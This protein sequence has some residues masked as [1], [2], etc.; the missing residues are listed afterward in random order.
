MIKL[1]LVVAIAVVWYAASHGRAQESE[2]ELTTI[3][4]EI[5]ERPVEVH[6][7]GFVAALLDV[8]SDSGTVSFKDGRPADDTKLKRKVCKALGRF[9][10]DV[11]TPRFA[12]VE[13]GSRCPARVH[14]EIWA[15]TVLAHESIHLRGEAAEDVAECKAVQETA[16]VAELLGASP[17]DARAIGRYAWT[18]VYPDAREDYRSID[19]Y[20]GGPLDTRRGDPLWP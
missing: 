3:A 7:Q 19:C 5:A 16:L 12:C 15:A 20:N 13:S 17:A 2:R 18:Q 6:C 14:E 1:V 4:S 9:S 10:S 8:S 11:L